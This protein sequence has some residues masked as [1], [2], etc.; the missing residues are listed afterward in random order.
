VAELNDRELTVEERWWLREFFNPENRQL[1]NTQ[2]Y[3]KAF[4]DTK[5]ESASQAAGDMRQRVLH[6]VAFGELMIEAG[7]GDH[8]IARGLAEGCDATEVVAVKLTGGYTDNG[9]PIKV[10]VEVPDWN[11]RAK[12]LGMAMKHRQ[13]LI[14]KMEHSGEGGGPLKVIIETMKPPD[15][16]D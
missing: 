2:I 12:F 5:L 4:P 14:D 11:A 7:L 8:T 15:K 9:D 13:L 3:L 1:N 16:A 6:K 10:P